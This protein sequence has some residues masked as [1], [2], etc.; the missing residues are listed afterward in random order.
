QAP[1][2]DMKFLLYDVLEIGAYSN[3]PRF[4]EAPRDV[5]EAILDGGAAF[6]SEV[7]QPLNAV[8]DR[9]GCKRNADGSVKTPDGFPAAFKQMSDDGWMAMS[10]DPQ[11]GGQGL[12]RVVSIPF[13]EMCS[14][15]NMAFSMYPGLTRGAAEAIEAGGS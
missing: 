4:S 3:L 7:L 2:R 11:W 12:P 1:L 5:V 14:S 15:A 9:Q 13:L 8:G 6:A 10:A